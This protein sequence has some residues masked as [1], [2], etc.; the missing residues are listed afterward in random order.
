MLENFPG[1]ESRKDAKAQRL[2]ALPPP[3]LCVFASLRENFRPVFFR[4]KIQL[5]GHALHLLAE[6]AAFDPAMRTLFIA[7]LHLGKTTVFRE[8]GLPL[9]DGPDATILARLTALIARAEA[10]TLVILGDVFH[11][12]ASGI[13]RALGAWCA[14]RPGLRVRILPGNHDRRIPWRE[15][16][17]GAEI[18]DEGAC[19]GAFRLTHF[20]PEEAGAITLCGHLHPG[21]AIGKSRGRRLR[22]PCF[23]LR[24]GALVLP[25]FGE[26]TGLGMIEREA[27]DRVWIGGAGKI[28]ELG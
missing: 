24:R 25:A 20:P 17:P 8:A 10:E 26:F 21:I 14:E 4:V 3:V 12:R 9:P 1:D 16:L 28:V 6:S 13:E 7:D 5:G 23:W 27:N 2:S 19:A 18:L 11:A 15:W 22:V